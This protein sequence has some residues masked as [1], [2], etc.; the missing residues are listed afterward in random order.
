ML[1]GLWTNRI[2]LVS[3]FTVVLLWVFSEIRQ[4]C[5]LVTL[6]F[7]FLQNPSAELD[8]VGGFKDLVPGNCESA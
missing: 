3:E 2:Q 1:L 8:G 5:E 6:C 7:H 4:N